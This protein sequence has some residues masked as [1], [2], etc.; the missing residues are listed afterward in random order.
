MSTKEKSLLI[1]LGLALAISVM[2]KD[3]PW[4]QWT[5][6]DAKKI[7]NDSGWGQTQT[8][9]SLAVAGGTKGGSIDEAPG[10][11]YRIRF[12]SAKPIRQAFLR[13]VQLDPKATPAHIEQAHQFVDTKYDQVV[14]IA[15]SYDQDGLPKDTR[16]TMSAFQAFSAGM[17]SML[18][19]KV[20]LDIKGGQRVFLQEYRPPS[21]DGMGAIFIFPR[22]VNDK[23]MLDAKSGGDIHFYAEFSNVR[24]DMRFKVSDLM[25]EGVL[26]Y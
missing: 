25:Y 17:T 1:L 21:G 16:L 23:P 9:L 6:K 20:Y 18:K 7:L 12:L 26:E 22:I 13:L 2:A 5:D 19:N 15:A 10:V 4:T 3:K 8:A 24:L 14:V 11:N